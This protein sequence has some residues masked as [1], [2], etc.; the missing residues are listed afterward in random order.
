MLFQPSEDQNRMR[1]TVS[2]DPNAKIPVLSQP[3]GKLQIIAQ[4]SVGTLVQVLGKEASWALIVLPDGRRGY[5]ALSNLRSL[6]AA[7]PYLPSTG[8]QTPGNVSASESGGF[9]TGLLGFSA[10]L[11]TTFGTLLATIVLLQCPSDGSQSSFT[12]NSCTVVD[13]PFVGVGVVMLVIGIV[14]LI[15]FFQRSRQKHTR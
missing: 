9:A 11:L 12:T 3:T 6:E 7:P 15:L 5:V 1:I 2:S 10:V 14:L 13:Q 4:L 8:R